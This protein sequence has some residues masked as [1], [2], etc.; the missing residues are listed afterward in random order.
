[1]RRNDAST[2]GRAIVARAAR[3]A[4]L[5]GLA[6]A[7]RHVSAGR[8][9]RAPPSAAV[10]QVAATAT[11]RSVGK[12]MRAG[13]AAVRH[14][15]PVIARM[16]VAA[17]TGVTVA[18]S[19]EGARAFLRSSLRK[20]ARQLASAARRPMAPRSGADAQVVRGPAAARMLAG[21]VP[22][23]GSPRRLPLSP[24]PR[25]RGALSNPPLGG[26]AAPHAA[27]DGWKIRST[28]R[29]GAGDGD[30]GA[31]P[32]ARG[33]ASRAAPMLVLSGDLVVDGQRLGQIALRAAG[34]EADAGRLGARVPNLR[35][36]PLPG[37]LSAPLP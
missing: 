32:G 7:P 29:A 14:V 13:H 24:E 23:P 9:R 31:G 22:K 3:A 1:M 30:G 34:R 4:R 16:H 5:P 17:A 18:A 33:G 19:S 2:V 37:G 26:G 15:A 6:L 20:Q 10:A 25:A 11:V 21:R 36:T 28:P 35:K 8:T 27:R 12:A